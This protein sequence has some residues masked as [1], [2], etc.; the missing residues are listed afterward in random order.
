MNNFDKALNQACSRTAPTINPFTIMK[1]VEDHFGIP[2]GSICSS[3]RSKTW[4]EARTVA[5]VLCRKYTRFSFSE[6]AEYFE[7]ERS[8]LA[9]AVRRMGTRMDLQD[10]C[11]TIVL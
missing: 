1:A 6:L 5:I 4:G 9:D 3:R 10:I 7:R 2:N 8:S 11:N